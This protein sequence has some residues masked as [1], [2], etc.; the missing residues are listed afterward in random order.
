MDRDTGSDPV[1]VR[2]RQGWT[3]AAQLT[4]TNQLRARIARKV[5]VAESGAEYFLELFQ[6]TTVTVST[7]HRDRYRDLVNVGEIPV[8]EQRYPQDCLYPV[9][10]YPETTKQLELNGGYFTSDEELHL[11]KEFVEA[12]PATDATSVMGVSMISGGVAR[13]EVC[14]TRGPAQEPF[15]RRDF[16]L[17]RDLATTLGT[18]LLAAIARAE[19]NPGRW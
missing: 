18:H 8:G 17:A 4:A 5:D 10:L 15:D 19:R 7:L 16:L 9:T 1:P 3:S 6:G 14:L 2:Y 13:G 11:F 12:S